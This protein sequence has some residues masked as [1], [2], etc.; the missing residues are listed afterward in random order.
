M[1]VAPLRR[2][3]YENSNEK[4]LVS[5]ADHMVRDKY[6]KALLLNDISVLK[7]YER[8]CNER[9][10]KHQVKDKLVEL[11][12]EVAGLKDDISEIKQLLK[13]IANR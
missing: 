10:E 2:S 9:I 5:G 3:E 4:Q 12:T 13:A 11:E 7:E 8:K 1:S 6:S